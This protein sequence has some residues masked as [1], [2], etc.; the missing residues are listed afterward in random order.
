[1]TKARYSETGAIILKSTYGYS[2]ERN[3]ADPLVDLIETMLTNVTQAAEPLRWL[4]DTFPLLRY[5]PDSFPGAG[6]KKKAREYKQ[7]NLKVADIPYAFV[8]QKMADPTSQPSYLSNLLQQ[9]GYSASEKIELSRVD[10]DDAKWTAATLYAGATDSTSV[11]LTSFIL[12]MAMYPEAQRKAQEEIDRVTKGERLPRFE[13]EEELPYVKAL[14]KE[15]YRWHPTLP[16][17][18]PHMVDEDVMYDGYLIPKGAYI[19]LAIQWLLHDPDVYADPD[20]FCPDR[21]LAPRNEP[22][23]DPMAFGSGRRI[24]PGRAFAHSMVFITVAQI[25]AVFDIGKAIDVDGQQM[26][27]KPEGTPGII[28]KPKQ[29]PCSIKPRSAKHEDLIRQSEKEKPWGKPDSRH[30]DW[31]IH[32]D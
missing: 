28:S 24:C 13:D 10:E 27:T 1:M 31:S 12:A 20:A 15:V 4:V 19:L 2:I 3:Q 6:F 14:V 17:S 5:L 30:L 22:S 8:K 18:F 11:S 32:S 25:L 9:L 29:F 7:V 23:P 16:M 26:G 21:Y